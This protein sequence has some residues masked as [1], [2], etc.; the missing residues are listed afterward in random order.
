MIILAIIACCFIVLAP[1][2]AGRV[3]KKLGL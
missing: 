2:E 3:L 1:E